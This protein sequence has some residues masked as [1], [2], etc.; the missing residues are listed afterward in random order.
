[1]IA[2][3]RKRIAAGFTLVEL[4]IVVA[5]IGILAAVAIPAFVKYIRKA[6]S[7]EAG[8]NLAKIVQGGNAYFD[9]DHADAS[10]NFL[11]KCFPAGGGT[12]GTLIKSET[13]VTTGC[14]PQK[15]GANDLWNDTGS[16]GQGWKSLSFSITDPHYYKY[17]YNG[18]C[19]PGSGT[20]NNI[21]VFT[22][23]AIGDLNCDGTT[24]LFFRTGVSTA[25]E[26]KSN[27]LYINP[28]NEIE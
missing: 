1:M 10:G 13:T 26:V 18:S 28:L 25:G 27:P 15:C 20:C 23:N 4:M 17:Q 12:T 14:C 5:I 19:C 3:F 22:A 2:G 16:D 6:K 21:G 9:V 24:A 11:P 8:G 7:A